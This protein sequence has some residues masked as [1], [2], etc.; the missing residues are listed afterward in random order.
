M[1]RRMCTEDDHGIAAVF[2]FSRLS[3]LAGGNIMDA[4][5][6]RKSLSVVRKWINDYIKRLES[7]S[8]SS[9]LKANKKS[10]Y[11]RKFLDQQLEE[12]DRIERDQLMLSQP[13]VSLNHGSIYT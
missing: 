1:F 9:N 8:P 13:A 12:C 2:P 3:N 4:E 11:Y 7:Q 5:S 6:C 10:K